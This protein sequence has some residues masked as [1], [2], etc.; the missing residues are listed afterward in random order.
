MPDILR[1]PDPGHGNQVGDIQ[2][3][4]NAQDTRVG[5]V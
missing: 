4:I 2:G 5:W 3:G 1:P